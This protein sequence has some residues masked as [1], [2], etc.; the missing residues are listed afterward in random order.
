MKERER[1]GDWNERRE[2]RGND[3]AMCVGQEIGGLG[4][5]VVFTRVVALQ[6]HFLGSTYQINA[7][8]LDKQL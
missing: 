8:E 4:G 6:H 3:Y 7:T 5:R 1:E 2:G